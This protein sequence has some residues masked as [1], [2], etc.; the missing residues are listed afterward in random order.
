MAVVLL[1][2]LLDVLAAVGGVSN[3]TSPEDFRRLFS[4]LLVGVLLAVVVVAVLSSLAFCL[5]VVVILVNR[6]VNERM[7]G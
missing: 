6:R 4:L 3:P 7:N 2:I 5:L 1:E